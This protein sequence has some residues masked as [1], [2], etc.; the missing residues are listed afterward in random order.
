MY[1]D[2]LRNWSETFENVTES[3]QLQTEL[4][5]QS[6]NNLSASMQDSIYNISTH[7]D[8]I[9]ST[10]WANQF[11]AVCDSISQVPIFMTTWMDQLSAIYDSMPRAIE[12]SSIAFDSLNFLK[13]ID[14]QEEY[15]ELTDDDCNSINTILQSP[16]ASDD[17]PPKVSKGKIAI[18]DFIKT[19][20]LPIL[21]I[22]F[23]ILLTAYYHKVDSIESQKRYIEES[24]LKE[25]ELQLKEEELHIKEQQLQNDI[26][27]KEILKNILIEFQSF[28]EAL[29]EAPECPHT[30][31]VL[32]DEVPE[33]FD[34]AP[35]SPDDTQ[36]N[37]L[38]NPDVSKSS[39]SA[40]HK[41]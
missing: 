15:I 29:P 34:E 14:F 27:Q 33:F 35:Y 9:I 4:A 41:E 39:E 37:D 21:A 6:L 17:N 3:L 25:K 2:I 26:E 18:S 30:V 28:S 38:S 1:D 11:S 36:D 7:L 20:L 16:G 19:I 8:Q 32:L 10:D 40:M 23:P 13:D 24:Q 5:Y 31:P 12:F 22:L